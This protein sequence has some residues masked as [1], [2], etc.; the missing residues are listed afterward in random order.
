VGAG[1]VTRRVVAGAA[2]VAVGALAA[3]GPHPA[4]STGG[5]S[6]SSGP[7]VT[8]A[9]GTGGTSSAAAGAA[10]PTTGGTGTAGTSS[11]T[12]GSVASAPELPRGGRTIFPAYRLVGYAGA[13]G[14]PAFGRLG[15]GR[16]DDR[17]AE[18]EK[19]AGPYGR[20][21]RVLPV[22][23]LIAVV[24][25]HFPG[26]DGRY[27][28]RVDDAVIAD[29]LAAARRHH[30]LL[31]LNVQPGR[32]AFLDEVKGLERWLKEPDVG[33]A[34]DPEWA[35]HGSQVPGRVFGSTTGAVIDGVSAWVD[36]LVR[37]RNLPQKALV[38][39]Q[40]NPGVVQGF[41]KVH[42]RDGVALIKSVDGIGSPGAKITTWKRL[43]KGLPPQIHPGFKLFFEEDR[44]EGPLMTP[45]QVLALR[46]QP[47]YVL[48]E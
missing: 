6:A 27:R 2:V 46:P 9:T 37:A 38:V 4:A 32:A 25:Q 19:L 35:V 45:A 42:R 24:A 22:L 10:T 5:P 40:L 48:Y 3:C 21:R 36:A 15:I 12:T 14:S 7:A 39:H 29:Y 18:I 13:P 11:A 23:E 16:I 43:V 8:P 17:V 47:E 44:A 20:G 33:L 34:L 41:E 26:G 28:V 1:P 30:A 31:L